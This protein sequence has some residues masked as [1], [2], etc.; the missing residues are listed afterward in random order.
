M[1]GFGGYNGIKGQGKVFYPKAFV[2]SSA[3]IGE[4]YGG[5]DYNDGG[6]AWG[7][8]EALQWPHAAC[9]SGGMA[10]DTSIPFVLTIHANNPC[11]S[12]AP[13]TSGV[14]V[15]VF[16]IDHLILSFDM[17]KE[18]FSTSPL[19]KFGGSLEQYYFELLDFNGLLGAIFY[20]IEGTDKSFDLWVMNGL[21]TKH[22]S[23]EFVIGV[24]RPL[25]FWKNG[26][27][28]LEST[29]QELALFDHSI[30]GLRDLSIH[31]YQKTMHIIAY[32]E[33]LVLL[34]GRSEHEECIKRWAARGES[35]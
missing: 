8:G 1:P 19:P 9:N 2:F 24:E 34:N 15:Q 7:N 35:N 28:F 25:G 14:V 22:F 3:V 10:C 31:V 32:V 21:W 30:Q 6:V 13:I 12:K 20:P 23:V 5:G 17:V 29:N 27:L 26:K 16:V 33:N 11:Y 18:K 4:R